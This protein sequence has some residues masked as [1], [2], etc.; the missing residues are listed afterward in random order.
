MGADENGNKELISVT[1]GYSE[2]TT[3][4]KEILLQMKSQGLAQA[5]KLAIGDGALGFGKAV[6]EV[7]PTTK[8]PTMLGS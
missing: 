2:S 1:D 4:W 3:S 5:P 6:S 8:T 7:F